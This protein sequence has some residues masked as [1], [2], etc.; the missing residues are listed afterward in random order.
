MACHPGWAATELQATG[1]RM[2][3][4]SL[5]EAVAHLSNRLFSQSAAMGALPTLYA[6]A[7]PGVRGGDYI[8]PDGFGETWGHPKKVQSSARSHDAEAAA[9]LWG[10][11]EA[12]TGVRYQAL[13]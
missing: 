13:E 10:A 1:P 3:G 5:L 6:A 4:S 11:S 8:G 2:Q 12:L 9:R 7:A